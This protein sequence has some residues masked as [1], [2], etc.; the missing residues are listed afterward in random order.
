MRNLRGLIG[1]VMLGLLLSACAT[2]S[3]GP[4][5]RAPPAQTLLYPDAE[6]EEAR[7]LD[8]WIEL[9]D[10]GKLD[11]REAEKTGVSE[12][13]RKAESRFIPVHLKDTI[14][15]TGYWGA[16]RVV[17]RGTIGAEVLVSGEILKSDGRTLALRITARDA[18]G[19]IWFERDYSRKVSPENYRNTVRGEQDAF[20]D[21]Y[22]RIANDLAAMLQRL[23]AAGVRNIRDA[24]A[25]RFAADIA[26]QPYADYLSKDQDGQV[27]IARLPARND[28]LYERVLRLKERDEMLVDTLNIRYGQFYDDM[29]DTYV[30]WRKTRLDEALALERVK[31]QAA[32]K[33]ILG[34]AAILGAIAIDV[35][36]GKKTRS[37][38]GSLQGVMIAGGA[39]AVKAG[40]EQGAE[41]D[42][43]KSAIQELG[44]SFD[45]EVTPMVVDVD[46]QT[47]E[48]TGSADVQYQHWRELLHRRYAVET[49][50]PIAPPPDAD[51]PASVSLGADTSG[52]SR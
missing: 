8:V 46:G 15:A 34:A 27:K 31:R 51:R 36:G 16:V 44:Q 47:I 26:P 45:A 1:A 2:S 3:S 40:I 30:N 48:L 39:M 33:K 18:L 37:R 6:I 25:L 43:H 22:N 24:A 14:Q 41:A 10:P 42:I 21:V 50:A 4:S 12:T 32:N 11:S 19:D 7:L 35:F 20:Q 23:S 49:G 38:T 52:A 9:F 13:I 29:W 5:Y 28:P 17:P